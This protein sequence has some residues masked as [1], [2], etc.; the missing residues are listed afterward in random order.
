MLIAETCR[1]EC[2]TVLG[3]RAAVPL[4][5]PETSEGK[6]AERN[7]AEEVALV[8]FVEKNDPDILQFGIILQPPQQNAFGDDGQ[9]RARGNA[10]LETHLIADFIADAS[11]A[12]SACEYLPS[13]YKCVARFFRA[14][15]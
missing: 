7:I 13:R 12:Q 4:V 5:I 3:G 6:E 2:L 14:V 10:R 11:T 15:A 8:K 9:P 1:S